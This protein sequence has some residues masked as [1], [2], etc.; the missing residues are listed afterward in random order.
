MH[1]SNRGLT[2]VEVLIAVSVLAIVAMVATPSL[3]NIVENSQRRAVI[4]DTLA[5]FAMA[6]QEAVIKGQVITVCPLNT[7]D[8]CGRDWTKP[9]TL[10]SDP[11][12][13]RVVNQESQVIRVLP[14]PTTGKLKVR[15]FRR[16]YF[17]YRPDGMI[18][19]DLG[20][21]TWCPD[22]QDARKA[23]RFLLPKSGMIRITRDTDGDGYVEDSTGSPVQC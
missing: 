3:S 12:N 9:L 2:L 5:F 13:K 10:F 15:S 14:P 18:Y 20:N 23:V 6:R 7:D 21:I 4:N 17:Q 1:F 11:D 16:S 22:D 19:S 8:R